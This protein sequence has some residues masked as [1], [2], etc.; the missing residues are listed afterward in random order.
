M[1][2]ILLIEPDVVLAQTYGRALEHAGHSVSHALTAQHGLDS[3][4]AHLPQVVI[5]EL[6]LS[7]H[8]GIEF[9]YE[10][11][12]Y[13]EWEGIPIIINTYIPLPELAAVQ[14]VLTKELGV[15]GCYYKPQTSLQ[16]LLRSVVEQ[17]QPA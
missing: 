11:R 14:V 3:A 6:Q 16:L 15:R 2:H 7:A 9:L 10:F 13:P 1:G 17:L 4:D 5:L 8:N 12:S